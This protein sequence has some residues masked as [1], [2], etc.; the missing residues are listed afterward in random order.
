MN[1][2]ILN[3]L[4]KLIPYYYPVG[5]HVVTEWEW[6]YLYRQG[7]VFCQ[8]NPTQR[9]AKFKFTGVGIDLAK[10]LKKQSY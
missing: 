6:S 1:E 4:L 10:N 5:M 7:H 3:P 8:P 2:S 9:E